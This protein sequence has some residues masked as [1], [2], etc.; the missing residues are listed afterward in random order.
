[1]IENMSGYECDACAH[2]RPLFSGDAGAVLAREFGVPLL[3]RIPFRPTTAA[4][5]PP[6]VRDGDIER[7]MATL[8]PPDVTA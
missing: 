2:T 4:S 1:V 7:L 6:S 8:C 3:A 5:H